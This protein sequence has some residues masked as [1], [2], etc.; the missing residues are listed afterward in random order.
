MLIDR[1]G[2]RRASTFLFL[3]ATF[4]LLSM[5]PAEASSLAAA[6]V[7]SVEAPVQRVSEAKELSFANDYL[8]GHGVAQDLKLSAYWLERAADAGAPDARM[9]LGYY[10]EAGIGVS[11]NMEKAA[12][13]YQ[14]AAHDGVTEAKV[15]LGL[16]YFW[17]TG[18]PESRGTAAE[19]FREAANKGSGLAAFELGSMYAKGTG[20]PRDMTAAEQWYE[21]GS[22]LHNAQAEYELGLLYF[23]G[24]DHKLDVR[25]AEGLLRSSAASSFVPA[26][27]TLGVLL[28]RYPDFAKSRGEAV[29]LLETAASACVWNASEAL[30]I[31]SRD[32][33][34][35]PQDDKA[36]YF[37]F[38]VATLE[39]GE[40]AQ[41]RLQ[42]DLQ[43]LSAKLTDDVIST[44]DAEALDW[45]QKHSVVLEF[46][47]KDNGRAKYALSAL[48][49]PKEG[50]HALQLLPATPGDR[51]S[52]SE[53]ET[54][55]AG[56]K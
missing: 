38:R 25:R 23:N 14:L 43:R 1:D 15:N 12:H 13:W 4:L 6:D 21:K 28:S 18:V 36:A 16:L 11:K 53:L 41:Q 26:M 47:Y 19:L 32:G 45:H 9:R 44:L 51:S 20:I 30:G 24:V 10:Y 31:L 7:P 54:A 34:G 5:R 22:K 49:A 50:E 3:Y 29:Q 46:V 8:F 40:A 55:K 37:N 27:F 35:V 39:G 33:N 52:H 56:L 42:A 17:G 2:A 48:A